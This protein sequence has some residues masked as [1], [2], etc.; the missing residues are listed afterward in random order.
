MNYDIINKTKE[1][2]D[3][4]KQILS[5]N[6]LLYS[7]IDIVGDL[8][9]TKMPEYTKNKKANID[10]LID[11][12]IEMINNL[13]ISMVQNTCFDIDMFKNT[14]KNKWTLDEVSEFLPILKQNLTKITDASLLSKTAA[15]IADIELIEM[16]IDIYNKQYNLKLNQQIINNLVTAS[17]NILENA[18]NKIAESIIE[19]PTSNEPTQKPSLLAT[20][21]I[22]AIFSSLSNNTYNK[23]WESFKS[24]VNYVNS[25]LTSG[26]TSG[27]N[28]TSQTMKNIYN[29]TGKTLQS[30]FSFIMSEKNKYLYILNKNTVNGVC[31]ELNK[32]VLKIADDICE[33]LKQQIQNTQSDITAAQSDITAVQSGTAFIQHSIPCPNPIPSE[34][35]LLGTYNNA[36]LHYNGNENIFCT[37]NLNQTITMPDIKSSAISTTTSTSSPRSPTSTSSN[38]TTDNLNALANIATELLNNVHAQNT[39]MN[40]LVDTAVNVI[41]NPAII[42]NP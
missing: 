25:G 5:I 9:N 20:S 10:N 31:E 32:I 42:N 23:R 13:K 41:S 12:A 33:L 14:H 16:A 17:V 37:N 11:S 38:I 35:Q 2:L 29:N 28:I 39:N 6:E 22:D 26:V 4:L 19:P 24:G 36:D 21:L 15:L 8:T 7:A 1:N 18:N 30:M 27:L 34:F 40:M 3:K